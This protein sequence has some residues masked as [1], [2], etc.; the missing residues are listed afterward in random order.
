MTLADIEI[1]QHVLIKQIRGQ[2]ALRRRLLEM[3]LTPNTLVCVRKM[4]PM[5]DPIELRLRGYSLTLRKEDAKLIDINA[6]PTIQESGPNLSWR[7]QHRHG[8]EFRE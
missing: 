2:G 4:A 7:H 6:M 8:G 1:G 5:G 3:G